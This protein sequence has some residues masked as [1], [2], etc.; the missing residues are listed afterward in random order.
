MQRNFNDF[1]SRV[2]AILVNSDIRNEIVHCTS[3]SLSRL[4]FNNGNVSSN[5]SIPSSDGFA[6]CG[7]HMVNDTRVV[8]NNVTGRLFKVDK[9][10]SCRDGGIYV[11]DTTCTAQYTGKTIHYGYVLTNTFNKVVQQSPPIFGTVRSTKML[12]ILNIPYFL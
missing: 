9:N 2:N 3:A 1:A 8:R 7:H 6:A 10:L 5:V 4:L 12:L 11:I